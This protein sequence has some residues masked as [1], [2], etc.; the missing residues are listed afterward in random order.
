M[1]GLPKTRDGWI[2]LWLIPFS[3]IGGAVMFVFWAG[4]KYGWENMQTG[5][6]PI[7]L[8]FSILGIVVYFIMSGWAARQA[9]GRVHKGV[10]I[11]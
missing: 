11:C 3:L 10:P 6:A 2:G 4:I 1:V 9:V 5:R 8:A 7:I